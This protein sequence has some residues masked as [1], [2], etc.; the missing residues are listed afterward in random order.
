[1]GLLLRHDVDGRSRTFVDI[2]EVGTESC[3]RFQD[4][5]ST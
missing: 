1:M 4:R 3:D 2:G 5:L